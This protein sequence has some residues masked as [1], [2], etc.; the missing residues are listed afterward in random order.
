[1]E[2]KKKLTH[3]E[4]RLGAI[5]NMHLQLHFS[6]IPP[7]QGIRQI[8]QTRTGLRDTDLRKHEQGSGHCTV[9]YKRTNREAKFYIY[10]P[11]S[12]AQIT[13][14]FGFSP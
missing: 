14:F 12:V 13:D 7:V 5:D 6:K 8:S 9:V 1:M 4:L 10:S 2:P 3:C 11:S